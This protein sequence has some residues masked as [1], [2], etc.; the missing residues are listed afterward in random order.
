[1]VRTFTKLSLGAACLL[2]LALFT[3]QAKAGEVDFQ[4]PSG[5]CTGAISGGVSSG[6]TAVSIGGPYSLSTIFDVSFNDVLGTI[7]LSDGMGDN[8]AG[9]FTPIT[10][11]TS[12]GFTSYNV[13]VTWTTVPT[14]ADLG[15]AIGLGPTH[16]SIDTSV[17][18]KVESEDIL[19]GATPEPASLLLL[20]TGLLGMGAVVR[21]RLIG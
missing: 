4:C 1:M 16:F 15:S 13:T 19:I 14:S 18:G 10:G 2:A 7:T 12:G 9:T 20:G 5:G 11:T 3:P 21:R 8:F 17:K 6:V